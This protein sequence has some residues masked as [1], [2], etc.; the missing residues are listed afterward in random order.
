M[1]SSDPNTLDVTPS[2]APMFVIVARSGTLSVFTPGPVYST[3]Q[4]TLP[5]VERIERSV[6]M[7]SLAPAN[8]CRRP[9]R[10]TWSTFGHVR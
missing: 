10:R 3:I 9:A 2:S 6:R 4:P 7:T 8:G 5:L 1:T